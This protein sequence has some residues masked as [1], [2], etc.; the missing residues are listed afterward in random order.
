MYLFVYGY[1]DEGYGFEVINGWSDHYALQNFYEYVG[2]HVGIDKDMFYDLIRNISFHRAVTVFN[3][4]CPQYVIHRVFSG[5]SEIN[6]K[7]EE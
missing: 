1:F 6:I 5:L 2:G 3:A 7:G 4:L